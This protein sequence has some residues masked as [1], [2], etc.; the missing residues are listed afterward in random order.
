M[1]PVAT[2]DRFM[3][4]R[5]AMQELAK[6]EPSRTRWVRLELAL[7]LAEATGSRIGAIRGL[8]WSDISSEPASICWRPEFDKRG[9]ERVIPI[10]DSL[11]EELRR[12]RVSLGAVGDGWL[13][14]CAEDDAP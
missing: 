3:A 14:P 4:T 13:F 12:I 8:R 6:K 5:A 2:Y 10:T 11:A 9:R 1:R 7:V